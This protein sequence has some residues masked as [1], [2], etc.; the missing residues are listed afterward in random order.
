MALDD[1]RLRKDFPPLQRVFDDRPPLVYFDSACMSLKPR[2]V[3]DAVV[4]YYEQ[5]GA[6][7][8]RS[9]HRLATEVSLRVDRAR[10]ALA[11]F[12]GASRPEEC[13]ILRNST[14]ALNVV[15]HGI[16]LKRGDAVLVSDREHNSNLVPWMVMA[17][18]VGSRVRVVPSEPDGTFSTDRLQEALAP[19]DV[20]VVSFVHTTNVDGYTNPIREIAE[21]AHDRGAKVVVDGAQ[22]TPHMP[23]DV[24]AL[25]VD[26]FALSVHKMLGP[27]AV[28]VLW[29]EWDQLMALAPYNVGG[30][31][32]ASVRYEGVEMLPAPA[33]FEAGLQDYAGIYGAE[34]AVRYLRPLGMDEVHAHDARINEL[35]S[36]A[37]S[38]IPGL[39]ILG[40][41]DVRLRGGILTFVVEGVGIHD[42][43]LTLDEMGNVAVRS[44]MHCSHA[45]FHARGLEGAVRASF[46]LYN[47]PAD[48]EAFSATLHEA[49]AVLRGTAC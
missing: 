4:E 23:V 30:S 11:E 14:E 29:G 22:S 49:V 48:V 15:A 27:T 9:V 12:I 31:T 44:G 25:G 37:V 35:A 2:P 40:P 19:G 47:T 10:G 39:R 36:R 16:G 1:V 34:A 18:A 42:I 20:R 33:R 6:C 32:V 46:Y 38:D 7:G 3:I 26:F 45:W 43:A 13:V 21:M 5:Q 24:R 41:A 8:G 28:G 17:Q